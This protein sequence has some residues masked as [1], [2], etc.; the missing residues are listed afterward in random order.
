MAEEIHRAAGYRH[1]ANTNLVLQADRSLLD[2]GRRRDNEPSGQA[3]SLWGKLDA[4]K[5]GD[6][7]MRTIEEEKTKR[8]KA[9][10]EKDERKRRRAGEGGGGAGNA[11]GDD[12]M[13]DAAAKRRRKQDR[14]AGMYGFATVLAATEDFEG[15]SYRPR[16]R[17]TRQTYEFILA[18]CQSCLG[19]IPQDVLRGAADEVIQILKDED[20]KVRSAG[21][22]LFKD[23]FSLTQLI[24]SRTL[25]K[26]S[27]SR[28]SSRL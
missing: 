2:S 23:Y 14:G 6:K 4:K 3:E 16:T 20:L 25:T 8:S 1:G 17:E 27:R 12:D 11:G 13:D 28:A 19:D 5:F 10:Q 15:L 22:F 18:F 26:R 9:K 24:L 21:E 7:A